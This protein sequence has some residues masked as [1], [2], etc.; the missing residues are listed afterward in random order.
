MKLWMS[1]EIDHDVAEPYRLIRMR[2]EDEINKL[3][4]QCE[5][6]NDVDKWA[7]LA[8]ITNLAGDS[9]P[10]IARYSPKKKIAEFRLKINHDNFKNSDDKKRYKL[11]VE[12]LI[13]S[14][15]MFKEINVP[16]FDAAKL[17]AAITRITS[18]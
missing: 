17:I 10:E 5:F 3:L 1:G 11:V 2:L 6:N 12:S 15:Y 7:Y 8:I 14:I 18:I 13:R 9:Y 16:A 4:S